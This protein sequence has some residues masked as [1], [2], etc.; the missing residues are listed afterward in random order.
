MPLMETEKVWLVQVLLSSE[1]THFIFFHMKFDLVL[2]N[3]KRRETPPPSS[4]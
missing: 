3:S 2:P 1:Q 4:T